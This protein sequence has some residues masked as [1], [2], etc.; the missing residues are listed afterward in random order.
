[1]GTGSCGAKNKGETQ[2]KLT[3]SKHP[4]RLLLIVF[5]YCMSTSVVGDLL[6]CTAESK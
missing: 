3:L 4:Q 2:L 6:A 5:T 1:M